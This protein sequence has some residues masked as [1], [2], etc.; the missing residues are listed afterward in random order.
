[1]VP[2]PNE[3]KPIGAKWIYKEKKNVKED[4]ERYKTWFVEKG[5]SQKHGI[6]YEEVFAPFAR[7]ETIR[8]IIGT[9]T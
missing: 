5:Y 2:R 3:K 8:L 7:L 1:L 4:V 9:A 6:D